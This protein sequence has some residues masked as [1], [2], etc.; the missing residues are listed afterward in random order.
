GLSLGLGAD[1]TGQQGEGYALT[2]GLQQSL[3]WQSQALELVQSYAG[4][5]FAGL[6]TLGLAGGTRS[7]YPL[8]LRGST[9]LALGTD[10]LWQNRL[11]LYYQPA[12]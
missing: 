5:P 3:T 11:T 7:L 2:L 10:G 8:G 1:L 9:S 6:H 12:A 4:L